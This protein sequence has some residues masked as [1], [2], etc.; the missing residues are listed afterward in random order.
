MNCTLTTRFTSKQVDLLYVG[1]RPLILNHFNLIQTGR[2]PGAHPDL[3]TLNFFHRRGLYNEEFMQAIVALW[4]DFQ[5]GRG[6]QCR[7]PVDYVKVAACALAVRTA[8]RQIRHGH[9][10]AWRPGIQ[11]TANGLLRQLEALRK[12]LK[13]QTIK[14]EGHHAFRDLASR[15][16]Q[17]LTWLRLTLLTCPCL[18]RRPDP[19]YRNW[20]QL[21]DEMVRVTI[22]ELQAERHNIPPARIMRKLVRDALKN[23]RRLRT[24]WTI[25]LLRRNPS[26][27]AWWFGEYVVLRLAW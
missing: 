9:L 26:I 1:L 21:I 4:K 18:I 20:Q 8:L 17:F 23:V 12:R 7:I 25:P 14:T 10:A 27:A 6:K 19:V 3:L 5:F 2:S 15:W 16:N 24:P 11:A 22:A 13:R